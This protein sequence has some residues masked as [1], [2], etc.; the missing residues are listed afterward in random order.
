[1]EGKQI[2]YRSPKSP[3]CHLDLQPLP[4]YLLRNKSLCLIAVAQVSK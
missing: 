3:N 1:M 2:V 4:T